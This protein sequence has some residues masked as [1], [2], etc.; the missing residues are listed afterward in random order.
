MNTYKTISLTLIFIFSL[1]ISPLANAKDKEFKFFVKGYTSEKI[2]NQDDYA[3]YE[4]SKYALKK[5]YDYFVIKNIRRYDR[6][7]KARGGGRM[8]Q[9]RTPRPKLRTEL[10]IHG[11]D[12]MPDVE[13]A[14]TS[15]MVKSE[16]EQKYTN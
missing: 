14:H 6:S 5:G 11:Y 9:K 12:A 13:G 8:G 3:A 10:I 16:I 15:S 7:K 4:A 2:E 1:I